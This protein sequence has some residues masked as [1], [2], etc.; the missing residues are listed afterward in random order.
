[1][2]ICLYL[3]MIFSFLFLARIF[4]CGKIRNRRLRLLAGK[5]LISEELGVALRSSDLFGLDN[6]S[7]FQMLVFG[8]L[9]ELMIEK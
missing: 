3:L 1:M 8:L 6:F 9:L 5:A 7:N 2:I 4:S